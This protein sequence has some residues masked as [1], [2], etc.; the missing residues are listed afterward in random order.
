MVIIEFFKSVALEYSVVITKVILCAILTGLI[1]YNREKNGMTVG[2]RTH[3][4]VGLSAVMLQIV[5]ITYNQL[6]DSNGDIFRLAGQMISGIGFLGAGA[7]IKDN[8]N[9][10]GLTTA[11]SIFFVACIGLAVGSGIYGP[12][13]VITIFAYLFLIDIFGFKK[14]ILHKKTNSVTIEAELSGQYHEHAKAISKS[15]IDVDAEIAYIEAL[16]VSME[17]SKI[18]IRV[19]INDETTIN[20][21][22]A[23]LMDVDCIVKTENVGK[24]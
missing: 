22:I 17:K 21:I 7:I 11:S 10:R 6:Y 20:D 1:G 19:N 23:S 15:L 3:I 2:I 13:I 18:R 24:K 14:F 16:S 9:V 8:R 5:S 4:L 12:A